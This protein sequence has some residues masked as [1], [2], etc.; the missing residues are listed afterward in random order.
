MGAAED[1][2]VTGHVQQRR[3]GLAGLRVPGLQDQQASRWSTVLERLAD[4]YEAW[5]RPDQA[6]RYRGMAE[7]ANTA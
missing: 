6:D 1:L 3:P 2:R 7:S 5:G 4:L